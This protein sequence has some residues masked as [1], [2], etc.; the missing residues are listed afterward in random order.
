MEVDFTA[1]Q[2]ARLNKV[3]AI[4]LGYPHDLL[5]SDHIRTVTAGDLKIETRR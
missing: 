3:S 5:A 4:D 2:L 1:D